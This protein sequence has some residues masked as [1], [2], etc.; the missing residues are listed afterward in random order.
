MEKVLQKKTGKK[1]VN[2]S[3]KK[4]HSNATT[5]IKRSN[6][7][8]RTRNPE[9]RMQ[10]TKSGMIHVPQKR[11]IRPCTAADNLKPPVPLIRRKSTCSN[12]STGSRI[13]HKWVTLPPT[14]VRNP[15]R[16]TSS[17]ASSRV[18]W[19]FLSQL[20]KLPKQGTQWQ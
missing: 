11:I 13:G 17:T 5:F 9:T 15:N 19:C 7:S 2:F 18:S 20:P 10:R 8:K 4:C 6:I 3:K 14:Q 16:N 12:G 1:Y